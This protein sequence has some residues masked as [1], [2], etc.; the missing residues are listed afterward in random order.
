MKQQ[1]LQNIQKNIEKNRQ[2]EAAVAN[3]GRGGGTSR[4]QVYQEEGSYMDDEDRGNQRSRRDRNN[5]Q[6]FDDIESADQDMPITERNPISARN[7]DKN[8]HLQR[9]DKRG[10][11]RQ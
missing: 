4:R 1:R 5:L 10:R 3:P 7:L 2:Q 11:G 9:E 6:D 8:R